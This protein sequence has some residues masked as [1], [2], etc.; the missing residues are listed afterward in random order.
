MVFIPPTL[1]RMNQSVIIILLIFLPLTTVAF[2][3][4]EESKTQESAV[5]TAESTLP[6]DHAAILNTLKTSGYTVFAE[7]LEKTGVLAELKQGQPFTCFAPRNDAFKM[8]IFKKLMEEPK[9]NE[10]LDLLRYHFIQGNQP[11]DIILISR[12][13][14]TLNGKF[15][16]YWISKGEISIN[17]HSELIEPDIKTEGG[18]IHGVSKILRP[19]VEG[20]LP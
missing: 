13:E 11:K 12:R 9:N 4:P 10:L 20:A 1:N 8:E 6:E 15:L 14:Q 19:E 17:N 5:P 18:V 7:L 16:Q 3:V 2:G